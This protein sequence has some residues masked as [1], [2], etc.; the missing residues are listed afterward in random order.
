MAQ[1]DRLEH[2]LQGGVARG[3]A[4]EDEIVAQGGGKD[5]G[6]LGEEGDRPT[7][8]S[9][10]QRVDRGPIEKELTAGRRD[11]ATDCHEYRGLA[12]SRGPLDDDMLSGLDA[13]ADVSEGVALTVGVAGAEVIELEGGHGDDLV[14][15]ELCACR[16]HRIDGLEEGGSSRPTFRAGVE[17]GPR[18]AEG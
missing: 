2:G 1:A 4:I 3:T 8:F 10:R 11:E 12:G 18:S 14:A 7:K 16:G 6:A 5:V 13:K 9:G 17:L 15:R